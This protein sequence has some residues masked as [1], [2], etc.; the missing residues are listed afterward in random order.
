MSPTEKRNLKRIIFW[1]F[2]PFVFMLKIIRRDKNIWVFGNF[3]GYVD[4]T[5]YIYE[6]VL[7]NTPEIEA[8]WI[9][10]DKSL[11]N[12]LTI[13]GKN[14]L[15]YYSLK[16][17]WISLRAGVSFMTNGYSDL[18]KLAS[19]N[20][21]V[22]NLWHGFP[23][24]K[25]VFD[26]ELETTFYS[27]GRFNK[28]FTSLSKKTLGFLNNKIDF[29][30]VS[31]EFELSRMQQAFMIDHSKF[32]I[33]GTP[34]WDIIR[35]SKQKNETILEIFN[36]Y[37]TTQGENILYAPSWRE[38]GWSKNQQ[39]SNL[40]E[41]IN[42]LEK[43]NKYFFIKKHPLTPKEEIMKWG[44]K[45]TQRINF[46]DNFDINESY[47]CI[48]ILITDFSSLIFDYGLLKKPVLYFITDLNEYAGNRGFYDDITLISNQIINQ[49]WKELLI[50]LQN[51]EKNKTFIHHEHFDLIGSNT[52]YDV[53]S[54]IVK[55]VQK[56][57][58][59]D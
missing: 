56:E 51:L 1:F 36:K 41:F 2:Y 43:E 29:F 27:L 4:N 13:E 26:A 11:F 33:L 32:R 14:A 18:N 16:G 12:S 30:F 24:K 9:T 53:R 39:V 59:N 3:K 58:L 45:E 21:C 17:V 28:V 34:R 10:K 49:N 54:S 25:I 55:L 22:I 19:I 7:D 5:K 52:K 48:D 31:S 15:Y 46:I 44:L 47:S 6:F 20:S 23:I 35:N 38:N 40:K 37:N 8:Y 57:K 50:S 42:Y